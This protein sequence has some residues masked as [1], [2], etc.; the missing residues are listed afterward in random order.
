MHQKISDE[1]M[2]QPSS[3]SPQEENFGQAAEPLTQL[4]PSK[5]SFNNVSLLK[6]SDD[7][8]NPFTKEGQKK[9]EVQ[10]QGSS[11]GAP[12][13]GSTGNLLAPKES[14]SPAEQEEA[15]E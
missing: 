14:I 2:A 12:K 13:A 5:I 11:L 4:K 1:L 10:G 6:K 8:A 7:A 9:K 3:P 15:D